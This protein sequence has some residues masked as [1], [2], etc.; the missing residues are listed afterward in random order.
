MIIL[1]LFSGEDVMRTF[2]LICTVLISASIILYH[3]LIS[4]PHEIEAIIVLFGL[5][6]IPLVGAIT[7]LFTDKKDNDVDGYHVNKYTVK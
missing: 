5:P 6:A 7:L 3:A 1:S 2:C 4:Q